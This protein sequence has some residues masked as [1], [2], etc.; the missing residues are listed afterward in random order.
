MRAKLIE[1][2]GWSHTGRR[3]AF[4]LLNS[5]MNVAAPI[6]SKKCRKAVRAADDLARTGGS[7]GLFGGREIRL[8]LQARCGI[9][10]RRCKGSLL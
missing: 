5:A 7:D 2:D 9:C 3:T 10:P 6:G 8:L 1:G 4:Q